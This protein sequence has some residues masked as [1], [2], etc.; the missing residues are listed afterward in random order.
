MSYARPVTFVS[1]DLSREKY[2]PWHSA[3]HLFLNTFASSRFILTGCLFNIRSVELPL[4][5]NARFS[6]S[7]HLAVRS[8]L[9]SETSCHLHKIPS[10]R[11]SDYPVVVEVGFKV[12]HLRTAWKFVVFFWRPN[13]ISLSSRDAADGR[14]NVTFR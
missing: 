8:A 13:H 12:F 9:T 10:C 2:L 3:D 7:H 11:R 1:S 6:F 14:R 5:K 4:S